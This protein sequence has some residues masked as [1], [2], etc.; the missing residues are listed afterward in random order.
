MWYVAGAF[1]FMILACI[2]LTPCDKPEVLNSVTFGDDGK[3]KKI[4]F[5]DMWNLLKDNR[6]MQMWI[7]TGTDHSRTVYRYDT[8]KWCADRELSDSNYAW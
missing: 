3:E 4:G 8:L 2:G 7:I 1:V 5:K 6:N